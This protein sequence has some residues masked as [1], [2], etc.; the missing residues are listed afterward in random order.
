[1]RI[2]SAQGRVSVRVEY[3]SHSAAHF[4]IV[5]DESSM[6]EAISLCLEAGGYTSTGASGGVEALAAIKGDRAIRGVITDLHMPGFDGIELIKRVRQS[7]PRL[8]IVVCSG[9]VSDGDRQDLTDLGVPILHK[10]FS[11]AQLLDRASQCLD[12]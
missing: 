8:R 3:P 5:D 4:L 7:R 9:H 12:P 11:L 1:M 10:P 2:R 6:R